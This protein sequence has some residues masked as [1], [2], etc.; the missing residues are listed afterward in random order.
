MPVE[1]EET[2]VW[3]GT[4]SQTTNIPKW[5]FLALVAA[6][7]TIGLLVLRD[8][9]VD[10][11]EVPSEPS[12]RPIF[13]WLIAAVWVGSALVAL[14]QYLRLRTTRYHLTTERLRITT[15]LLSTRTEELEL[16]RVR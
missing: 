8:G 14:G 5:V 10:P 9:A 13:G 6:A 7:A 16:R 11:R 1:H 15:G 2:T 3:Q 4:P 12:A